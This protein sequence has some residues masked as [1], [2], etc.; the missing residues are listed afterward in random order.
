MPPIKNP[1]RRIAAKENLKYF[2][3]QYFPKSFKLKWSNYHLEML[4]EIQDK[5]MNGGKQALAMPR[6]SGKTTLVETATL[7]AVL[8]GYSRFIIIVG[9]NVAEA[10]KI[11]DSLKA[12]IVENRAILEDFPEAIYPFRKLNGSALLARGQLYLGELTG[13]EW[14][15][16]SITFPKILGSKSSGAY[17]TTSGI[18]GAIRGKNRNIDGEKLRP[19]T[20]ILDDPQTDADAR[21]PERV[22]KLKRIIDGTIEGLVGPGEELTMFMTCTIIQDGDL[23]SIYLDR[24]QKAQ[25]HGRTFKMIEKMPDRMDM[26]EKYRD[27]RKNEDEVAATIYYRKNRTEMK[28]GAIVAWEENYTSNELDALQYAMN[29]WADNYLGFMSEYQNEPVRPGAGTVIVDAKTIR[30]RLNGLSQMT[31]PIEASTLTGFIDVHDDLLYYAVVA[32]ADD[33]TGYIV[34]YGTYPEQ[35]RR[36]FKKSDKDLIVMKK[37]NESLQTK[38][39]IQ[40]GLTTLL[41]DMVYGDYV[42]ENNDNIQVVRFSKILVDSGYVPEVVEAAIR[43]VNSPIVFPSKG[44]GVKATS[45]PMKQWQRIKGRHFGDYWIEERPQGRAYLTLTIDTNYWKR[46]L[47][48]S[49]ALGAGARSGLTFWGRN[50]ETHLMIS[51]HCNS[52]VAKFVEHGENKLYEWELI[53][54]RDNHFFDC[55]VGC[56]TAASACGIKLSGEEAERT[57]VLK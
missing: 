21:S 57:A 13:I 49:F 1:Q 16:N 5:L 40:K 37:G 30:T 45:K 48:D 26:W 18:L 36:M 15:P 14:K 2:C 7:W 56:M 31:L 41:N 8:Y 11:I 47:H 24:T 9:S 12:S 46:R 34:D 38:A 50:S 42:I 3:E 55:L 35:Y 22:D 27:I 52:E 6:G 19:D 43:L 39:V 25:W 29:K 54:G 23:A 32:W 44:A 20:V 51:E 53:P 28:K 4:K 33:F 10:K 17:I